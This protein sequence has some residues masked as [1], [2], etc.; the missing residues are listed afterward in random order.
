MA[1][2]VKQNGIAKKQAAS[3]KNE[4][5]KKLTKEAIGKSP[6]SA[7]VK[8]AVKTNKASVN[9]DDRIQ[10]FEK[11]R[12]LATQRE[13]LVQTLNELTKFNY[14]QGDSSSFYLR[15]S[16]GMEFKTTNSNLIKLVSTHL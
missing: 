4:V 12:G 11:L 7:K 14:N 3:S 15:D 10:K 13:R 1:T 2:T 6:A 8:E 5:K 16:H 9:L